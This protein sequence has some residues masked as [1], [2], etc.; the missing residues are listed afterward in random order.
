[1]L[2][3]KNN[4]LKQFNLNNNYISVDKFYIF[5]T[6]LLTRIKYFQILKNHRTGRNR[7]VGFLKLPNLKSAQRAINEMNGKTNNKNMLDVKFS[8]GQQNWVPKHSPQTWFHMKRAGMV[9]NNRPAMLD[10][11]QQYYPQ[12]QVINMFI[13][14]TIVETCFFSPFD[15][16][17]N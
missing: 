1:M 2:N 6:H 5:F 15:T 8:A 10:N 3:K 11:R 9:V 17:F 13:S 7:N 16:Y 4:T 12:R 14:I